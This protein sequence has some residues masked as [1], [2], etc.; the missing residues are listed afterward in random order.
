MEFII[1]LDKNIR[2]GDIRDMWSLPEYL[3]TNKITQTAF[4]ER[5]G[6]CQSLVSYWVNRKV[7]PSLELI[8]KINRET[9]GKVPPEAWLREWDS[10]S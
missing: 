10:K 5:M 3:K 2:K 6:V 7:R 9:G 1:G 4:A 8:M